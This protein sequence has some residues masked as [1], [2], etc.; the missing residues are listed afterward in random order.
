MPTAPASS[1]QTAEKASG[2]DRASAKDAAHRCR[3]L[4]FVLTALRDI[5]AQSTLEVAPVGPGTDGKRSPA[6]GAGG[7]GGGSG[8]SGGARLFGWRWCGRKRCGRSGMPVPAAACA[9]GVCRV[10]GVPRRRPIR[11]PERGSQRNW[12]RR[13]VRG[14]RRMLFGFA[15][16][17]VLRC[18]AHRPAHLPLRGAA[19]TCCPSNATD[20][21]QSR[22]GANLHRSSSCA[23]F[24]QGTVGAAPDQLHV[25]RPQ[26]RA[27]VKVGRPAG[28]RRSA[29][30]SIARRRIADRRGPE[31]G[32]RPAHR[33]VL[34]VQNFAR[35]LAAQ[36][37]PDAYR[38][39]PARAAHPQQIAVV[40]RIHGANVHLCQRPQMSTGTPL[41]RL[42]RRVVACFETDFTQT[43]ML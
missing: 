25:R 31:T 11:M 16:M 36:E 17:R 18:A 43:W 32:Q 8:G 30:A 26:R 19:G 14:P 10:M 42:H 7:G 5:A 1:T 40:I 15:W 20:P 4:L 24:D 13:P 39:R 37:N 33:T 2:H 27:A 38:V 21:G 29:F 9:T 23:T 6:A 22:Q 12:K 3:A 35:A 34:R 28:S 41:V